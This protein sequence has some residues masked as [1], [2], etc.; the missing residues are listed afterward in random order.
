[1]HVATSGR[2][3]EAPVRV[4]GT[5]VSVGLRVVLLRG[6][7]GS[8]LLLRA[9]TAEPLMFDAYPLGQALMR[10]VEATR[11]GVVSTDG[12]GRITA[13]NRAFQRLVQAND[14]EALLGR[15]LDDWLED[16]AAQ[17]LVHKA[18]EQGIIHPLRL[19]VRRP[20]GTRQIVNVSATLLT[21]TDRAGVGFILQPVL[22]ET[23]PGP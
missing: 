4:A 12:Q 15:P 14:E 22:P 16:T 17:T 3:A 8:R 9:R 11:D 19:G 7:T 18:Q 5:H 13:A 1:L 10:L 23:S 20:D 6:S 21:E 2:A